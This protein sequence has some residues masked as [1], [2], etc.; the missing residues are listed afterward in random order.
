MPRV[1]HR[2]RCGYDGEDYAHPC[3]GAG[4]TCR[5]PARHR[6][7]VEGPAALS[8]VQMKLNMRDTWACDIC[9]TSWIRDVSSLQ[10]RGDIGPL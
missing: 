2:C 6:F 8:G 3:H 4:Y 7:Y 5:R 1:N 10:Q 9:W